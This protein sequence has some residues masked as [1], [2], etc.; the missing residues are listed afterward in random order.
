MS[1]L[2]YS[3]LERSNQGHGI[4]N[5]PVSNQGHVIQSGPVSLVQE[6]YR[7]SYPGNLMGLS[8]LTCSDLE[9]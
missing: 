5:G 6:T 9:R 8:D 1:D 3:D 4:Q 7:N 2:T